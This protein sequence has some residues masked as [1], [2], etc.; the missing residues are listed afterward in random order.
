MAHGEEPRL[1]QSGP[2]GLQAVERSLEQFME[3]FLTGAG[4]EHKEEHVMN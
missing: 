1:E 2:E 4:E 3:D